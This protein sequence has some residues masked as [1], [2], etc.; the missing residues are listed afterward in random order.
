VVGGNGANIGK[1]L[2]RRHLGQ[3]LARTIKGNV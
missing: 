2:R 3:A 1:A